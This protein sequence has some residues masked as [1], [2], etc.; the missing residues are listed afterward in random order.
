MRGASCN[1]RRQG[2]VWEGDH[3]Y[4]GRFRQAMR[5]FPLLTPV[6]L[7]AIGIAMLAAPWLR[8]QDGGTSDSDRNAEF[9][10]AQE[11]T[12]CMTLAQR[13]PDQALG[14]AESRSEEHTSELQS[15]MPHSS[16]V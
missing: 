7:A 10:N 12:A 4:R 14:S 8:A 5:P 16:A 3:R 13:Q 6:F 15:L 1:S 9:V 2:Q 11:Y